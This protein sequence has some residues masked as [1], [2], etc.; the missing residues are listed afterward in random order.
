MSTNSLSLLITG[1]NVTPFINKLKTI[2]SSIFS[3][4]LK[5]LKDLFITFFKNLNCF[6]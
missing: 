3:S 1:N 2:L 5:N 6:I 4:F